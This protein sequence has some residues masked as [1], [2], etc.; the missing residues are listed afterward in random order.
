MLT[1]WNT[2]VKKLSWKFPYINLINSYIQL[3]N[4]RLEIAVIPSCKKCETATSSEIFVNFWFD[5][6]PDP[7]AIDY[8]AGRLQGLE[9]IKDW[10]V[11]PSLYSC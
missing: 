11:N 7:T 1:A 2:P 4:Y 9:K 3:P 6:G 10:L 8:K 5:L